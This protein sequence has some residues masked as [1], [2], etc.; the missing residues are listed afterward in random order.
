MVSLLTISIHNT[1]RAIV[2]TTVII[3][4]ENTLEIVI[5]FKLERLKKA[6]INNCPW[7]SSGLHKSSPFPF[8]SSLSHSVGYLFVTLDLMSL[9]SIICVE[10]TII[11][12]TREHILLI[13]MK[14]HCLVKVHSFDSLLGFFYVRLECAFIF[15]LLEII[16]LFSLFSLFFTKLSS[17]V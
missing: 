10:A 9:V 6:L 2:L 4:T 12:Y 5:S 15:I 14:V 17:L 13:S 3:V 7:D 11:S 8:F 1:L 16:V